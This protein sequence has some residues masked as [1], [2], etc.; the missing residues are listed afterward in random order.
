MLGA[1]WSAK[2]SVNFCVLVI[3]YINL[4]ETFPHFSYLTTI[5]QTNC[6]ILTAL[7]REDKWAKISLEKM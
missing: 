5:P 2:I 6:F 7:F 4:I 1:H 3:F